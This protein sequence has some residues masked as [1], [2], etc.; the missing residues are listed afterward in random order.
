[1][2]KNSTMIPTFIG[3][4]FTW[5]KICDDI[6]AV[7]DASDMPKDFSGDGG[8]YVKSHVTG[9]TDLFSHKTELRDDNGYVYAK[10]FTCDKL[11]NV[12]VRIQDI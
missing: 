4:T 8:F 7:C 2:V 12:I 11:P 3:N 9:D 5:V 6:Y 10:E 1:M